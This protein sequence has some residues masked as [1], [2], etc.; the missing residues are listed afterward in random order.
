MR[1]ELNYCQRCG[2]ALADKSIEDKPRRYCPACGYVAFLDPKVAAAVLALTNGK[3]VMVKRG[4]EPAL[5]RWAFPSGFVDRGESVEDAIESFRKDQNVEDLQTA[6]KEASD[7]VRGAG[8][9]YTESAQNIEEGMG[10]ESEQSEEFTSAAGELENKAEQMDSSTD[11]LQDF[12]SW[13]GNEEGEGH[14]RNQ[15]VADQI[16]KIDDCTDIDP[17]I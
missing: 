11:E 4:V 16:A 8:E 14:G 15:W 3:L 2:H 6:I 17:G 7:E 9:D 10:H 1:Q 5:G 13:D 12:D